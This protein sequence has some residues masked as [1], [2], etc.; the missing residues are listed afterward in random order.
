M[1]MRIRS[2]GRRKK[3]KP[4]AIIAW[5]KTQEF[6]YRLAREPFVSDPHAPRH[7]GE[8]DRAEM[9]LQKRPR[10]PSLLISIAPAQPLKPASG[11]DRGAFG[12]TTLWLGLLI[13]IFTL[14][15]TL[16]IYIG[17]NP[18]G[19][20]AALS[21]HR[22][23]PSLYVQNAE[24]DAGPDTRWYVVSAFVDTRPLAFRE[25]GG[26]TLVASGPRDEIRKGKSWVAV[27]SRLSGSN[28]GVQ[29][30]IARIQCAPT[31]FVWFDTH[32]NNATHCG[33]TIFCS[34]DSAW[35]VLKR[36]PH[37]TIGVCLID[38]AGSP[39]GC[40]RRSIVPVTLPYNYPEYPTAWGAALLAD[41]FDP[42]A[43]L[44]A[45]IAHRAARGPIA[46]MEASLKGEGGIAM[47][48]SPISGGIY[49]STLRFF[50]QYYGEMGVDH[51]YMYMR[52][53]SDTFKALVEGIVDEQRAAHVQ[54]DIPTLE[55]VPWCLQQD[56]TYGCA[57]GQ[58]KLEPGFFNVAA[59]N[60]GQ[61]LQIQDCF[62][63]AMGRYRWMLTVDLD[64]YIVPHVPYI[65]NLKDMIAANVLREPSGRLVAPSEV[66]YRTAFYEPCLPGDA[67]RALMS[68]QTQDAFF[69]REPESYPRPLW[70]AVRISETFDPVTRSKFMCD[71][72]TCDRVGIH[73]GFTTLCD[74]FKGQ[75]AWPMACT[76]APV[77]ELPAEQMLIH[78]TRA[79]WA[80]DAVVRKCSEHKNVTDWTFANFLFGQRIRSRQILTAGAAVHD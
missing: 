31:H 51:V 46:Q 67:D 6:H 39:T 20:R 3:D 37:A 79:Q 33:A 35:D 72:L 42:S 75:A 80:A 54:S 24:R 28:G 36:M 61:I 68:Q 56:A 14:I 40:A 71:T 41:A 74:R 38:D 63:R 17:V 48:I 16:V 34:D 26:V 21:A 65:Q 49:T 10:R 1:D 58:H 44:P 60:F 2:L 50:L 55:I 18:F 29:R 47:C 9:G 62:L 73:F 66:R 77:Y 19:H 23:P 59:S 8:S 11:S 43:V 53:P 5:R 30:E 7:F 4:C 76:S 12:R 52:R 70:A 57:P 25:P 78:H 32:P 22:F 69:L 13:G 64:E 45:A 15:W 27:I